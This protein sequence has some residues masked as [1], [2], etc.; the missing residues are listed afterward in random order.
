MLLFF[1]ENISVQGKSYLEEDESR[2]CIRVLRLGKGDFLHLT[3]GKGVLAKAQISQPHPKKCQIE[4]VDYQ[5]KEK[6]KS[7]YVHLAIAPTKNAERIEWLV[8]KCVEMGIDE[9]SFIMTKHT[10]RNHFNTERVEK[11]AITA[12]KQSL[13]RWLPKINPPID[14]MKFIGQRTENQKF[15][16]YVDSDNV[17]TLFKVAQSS[18]TYCILVGPEGDFSKEEL[19][20]ALEYDF[21][22]VSLG[23]NRLRTET[24]GL[25]ACCTV[26]LLNE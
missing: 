5:F 23:R 26:N 1:K 21:Q 9:I 12:L 3:N 2:H 13:Q 25:V 4:I 19:Q 7:F 11:K 18:Q 10:E 16:A 20:V 22:K 6:N 24:A 17:Q 15:I 14:F 8:E